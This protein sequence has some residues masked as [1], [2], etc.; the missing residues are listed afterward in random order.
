M[1]GYNSSYYA[2]RWGS[3]Y[4]HNGSYPFANGPPGPNDNKLDANGTDAN[5][6]DSN[7]TDS[8]GTAA[9]APGMYGTGHPGYRGYGGYG[10]GGYG[11]YG[12]YHGW[13]SINY[14]NH[15]GGHGHE[16]FRCKKPKN[17]DWWRTLERDNGHEGMVPN[18]RDDKKLYWVSWEGK[19][20]AEAYCDEWE[21]PW[22]G[23]GSQWYNNAGNATRNSTGEQPDEKGEVNG[24]SEAEEVVKEEHREEIKADTEAEEK[25]VADK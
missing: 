15:W 6:T 24:T 25:K 7:G 20:R 11:G 14:Q 16:M 1:Y 12:G 13:G 23:W 5:G 10:Y 21:T 8:N 9:A 17:T 2:N 19:E 4:G 22:W 3:Y 18:N